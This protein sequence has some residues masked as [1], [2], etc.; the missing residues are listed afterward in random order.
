MLKLSMIQ[1]PY[2]D[3]IYNNNF[4]DI[5]KTKRFSIQIFLVNNA[6]VVGKSANALFC[7]ILFKVLPISIAG[8]PSIVNPWGS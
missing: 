1:I 2:T 7:F 4:Y 3:E 5:F 8:V 6:M